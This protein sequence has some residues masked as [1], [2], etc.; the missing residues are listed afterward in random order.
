MLRKMRDPGHVSPVAVASNVVVSADLVAASDLPSRAI[1]ALKETAVPATV[2]M[3]RTSI[4]IIDLEADDPV[5]LPSKPLVVNGKAPSRVDCIS[6]SRAR[7]PKTG[8]KARLHGESSVAKPVT[9]VAHDKD[10]QWILDDQG[11]A[12]G[13]QFEIARGITRGWWAWEDITEGVVRRLRGKNFEK[14][15]KVAEI[16]GKEAPERLSQAVIATRQNI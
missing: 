10:K 3:S 16:I 5:E 13:V 2:Q 12:K 1:P 15:G 14:A 11:I 4:E 9:I 6:P 7:R 8:V